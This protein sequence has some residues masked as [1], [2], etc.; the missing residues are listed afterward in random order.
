[1]VPKGAIQLAEMALC[2]ECALVEQAAT[3]EAQRAQYRA[4]GL[5]KSLVVA[6]ANIRAFVGLAGTA[7]F[8]GDS[9]LVARAR[10]GAFVLAPTAAAADV[11]VARLMWRQAEVTPKA[12][13][14]IGG[15]PESLTL[16][17]YSKASFAEAARI[18]DTYISSKLTCVVVSGV[19]S[20]GFMNV[21]RRHDEWS[22]LLDSV[23]RSGQG[24]YVCGKYSHATSDSVWGA[25]REWMGSDAV[26]RLRGLV[27]DPVLIPAL[28]C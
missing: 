25:A 1:M 3:V 6:R 9:L 8:L 10:P 18:R 7:P 21:A 28:P 27:G 11:A 23:S 22:A 12:F 15:G 16:A 5:A 20:G 14:R 13:T 24:L 4:D 17:S 2:V 26:E 19:G